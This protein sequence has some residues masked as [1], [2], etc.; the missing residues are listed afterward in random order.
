MCPGALAL[1][2][3]AGIG[4]LSKGL[5][6]PAVIGTTA[7]LLPLFFAQWRTRRYALQLLVALIAVAPALIVWPWALYMRSEELFAEWLN[8]N[9]GRFLGYYRPGAVSHKGG[10]SFA[11]VWVLFPLWIYASAAIAIERRPGWHR[12]GMQI[13]FTMAFVAASVLAISASMRDLYV[14]P[15]IPA[16][17]LAAVSA[18]RRPENGLESIL[19][20]ACVVLATVAALF[21]W[22]V[23]GLLVF[24]GHIPQGLALRSYLP[25]TFHMPVSVPS[26][27]A[28]VALTAAFAVL[29]L[30]RRRVIAPSLSLWI[31]LVAL[32]WGLANTLWL[33]WLDA[34]KGRIRTRD[35][36]VLPRSAA[37]LAQLSPRGLLRAP[38]A[39]PAAS[40]PPGAGFP[41][42][43]PGV[44][45]RSS[46]GHVGELRALRAPRASAFR[47]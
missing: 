18:L 20:G 26:L 17:A 32:V 29:V 22:L 2:F 16:L 13:G 42:L 11:L 3:G 38:V 46:V 37:A 23:W 45:R 19:G 35:D 1:G 21:M 41:G 6:A 5:L 14:L 25:A 31:G 27:V 36:L 4:F 44:A 7:L 30:V 9:L 28:A 15:L 24:E 34:A 12:A 33:P 47:G 8:N 43:A 10:W 40:A 39:G